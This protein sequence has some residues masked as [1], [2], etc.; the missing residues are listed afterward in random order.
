MLLVTLDVSLS[1][2]LLRGKGRIEQMKKQ[3]GLVRVFNAASSFK[4]F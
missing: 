3:V 2:N 4:K 1:E